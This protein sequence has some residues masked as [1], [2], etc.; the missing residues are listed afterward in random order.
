MVR[1][2]N[3][4]LSH[5][6]DIDVQREWWVDHTP[7]QRIN[8]PFGS[9]C[10]PHCNGCQP[11]D[12]A[13]VRCSSD[14]GANR[15]AVPTRTGSW[16]VCPALLP[17]AQGGDDGAKRPLVYSFGV[18]NEWYF[19]DQM[20]SLG[21]EVFAFDPT[22]SSKITHESRTRPH[23]HFQYWGLAAADPHCRDQRARQ[24]G[25]YGALGGEMLS[26]SQIRQRLGH[27]NQDIAI[28]K[29]VRPQ[30]CRSAPPVVWHVPRPSPWHVY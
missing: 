27:E 26:L 29:M 10:V 13:L 5:S 8:A 30:P 17:P 23:I 24:G 12:P 20:A 2:F 9:S 7:L 1:Q 25:I 6:N 14:P 4:V 15:A 19:E 21:Y 18:V 28:L 3:K 16:P 11:S 22:E